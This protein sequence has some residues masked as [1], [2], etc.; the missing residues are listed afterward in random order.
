MGPFKVIGNIFFLTEAE[1][2]CFGYDLALRLPPVLLPSSTLSHL[3][4]FMF[5][6]HHHIAS[7]TASDTIFVT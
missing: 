2:C 7:S 3:S 5:V 1:G 6:I 4:V